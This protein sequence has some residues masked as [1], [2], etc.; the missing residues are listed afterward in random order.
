MH[1]VHQHSVNCVAFDIYLFNVYIIF[2][3][4]RIDREVHRC[5]N[6]VMDSLFFVY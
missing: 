2:S 5:A 4:H 6:T 3:G 1:V